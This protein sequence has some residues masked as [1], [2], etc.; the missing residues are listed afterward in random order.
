MSDRP[1]F[2][3][4]VTG[5]R[6]NRL[7]L[8]DAQ[9]VRRYRDTL[10]ALARGARGARL[11]AVSA[12]AEGADRA[13]A[14]AAL[15]CRY[16]LHAILPFDARAYEQTFGDTTTVPHYRELL[17]RAAQV[18]ELPG[19]LDASKEAYAAVGEAIVSASD[20]IVA[21]WD[22]EPA[23]GK[24]GTPDVIE[25]ALSAGRPV[26]WIDAHG[27]RPRRLLLPPKSDRSLSLAIYKGRGRPLTP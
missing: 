1:T 11:Q 26:I 19:S 21:V 7:R 5:H 27:R 6:P 3:V 12:L 20:V 16:E 22:G 17:T 18:Q 15:L 14:E 2:T 9:L 10:T 23:A 13:F 4:G 8:T 25:V 24:G